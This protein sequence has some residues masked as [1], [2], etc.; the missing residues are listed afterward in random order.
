MKN[1]II[2]L[3]TMFL[4][5]YGINTS[6]AENITQNIT[7][8]PGWN[9]V[10]LEV[11]PGSKD[12]ATVFAG[13]ADL[14]S[15]WKWNPDTSTVEFIQDPDNLVPGQPQWMVY[16]PG[17]PLLT[18]LHAIDGETPYLINLGGASDV[19]WTVTGQPAIPD[20]DWKANSFNFVG[21]HLA[22]GQEPFFEDFFSASLAH[23]G[24]EIYILNAGNWEQV[25]DP[26][27]TSMLWGEAFWIYCQ[28]SSEFT[29]PIS[30]QLEQGTG[31]HY[32]KTLIE[33]NVVLKNQSEAQKTVSISLSSL[34]ST[35]YYWVFDPANEVAGWEA[36]P[37]PLNLTIPASEKQT[38]RLGVKRE[39]LTDDT[40]YEAN[41]TVTD[42]E[43]MTI[44]VPVSVVGISYSGLW[45]GDATIAK[46]NQ[47]ANGADPNTP[48]KTGSEFSFRL[49]MHAEDTG[50]IRLLSQV[51]QMWQEGT[52]KPDPNDLGKLIVDEPGHFVLFTDDAL[53]STYSGAAMRD[54]KPVGRRISAPAF[55]SLTAVQGVMGGTAAGGALDPSVGNTLTVGIT[56]SQDDPT[57]PFRHM[58]HPDH[59]DTA[60][61]YQVV[62]NIL[63]TFAHEDSDG[64]PI[65]GVPTLSW[66]SSEIGGIYTESITGLHKDT[67]NFEGT[68][69]MHKV[70]NVETLTQ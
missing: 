2:T 59:D 35:V 48:V 41:M 58:Y 43:G 49:V 17:N 31:I 67:L 12:P 20:I 65:T 39:G 27:T 29:G 14:Q 16:Y 1:A 51:I 7:L 21:F 37:S 55:P 25:T 19:I 23:A 54:G 4:L 60:E 9:A 70:S 38:L 30:A 11:D 53:I 26:A 57:N 45:V 10:F 13:V 68:F 61:S 32:G 69:L 47:P 34:N 42:T 40:T 46:V 63:L 18:N 3:V 28:G 62:R 44:L 36:F 6:E 66:G 8:H 5:L 64:R 56:L 33:Q 22:S 52:W 15:V 24:Q 50:T